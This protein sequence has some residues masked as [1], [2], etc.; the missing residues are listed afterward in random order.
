[1]GRAGSPAL[2]E[3]I[4]LAV[5]V[6][7]IALA[8]TLGE[9]VIFDLSALDDISSDALPVLWLTF[10]AAV[11]YLLG[12]ALG[13]ALHVGLDQA[14]HRLRAVPTAELVSGAA[15]AA[16]GFLVSLAL[17]WPVLLF[18]GWEV[19]IPL[20]VLVS[21]VLTA[22]GAKLGSSRGGELLRF[23]G[24]SGRLPEG[25]IRH[26]S[27]KIVDSSA[28]VDGRIVDVCRAGFLDG[29]LVIPGFVLTEVQSL[30]DA[31]DERRRSRG[32]RALDVLAALQRSA[33]VA[34][35]VSDEDYPEIMEVDAKLLALA[36]EANSS[37]VTVDSNLGR[38]AEVQGIRVLNLHALAETLRPPVLPG[39][40]LHLLITRRGKESGQGVGHLD[41]GTMVVVEG[42]ANLEGQ[43]V[44]AEVSS[45]L[46]TANGRLVFAKLADSVPPTDPV[47]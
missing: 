27:D 23:V 41:D 42:A 40:A 34:I 39:D 13:R 8:A 35:S 47:L 24:V 37:L 10:A 25:G 16:A 44:E 6:A 1:V 19:T 31:A 15:G 38:I 3:L 30:A 43:Q 33:G 2:V 9:Q 18:E 46:A 12:G 28:L 22:A 17:V 14:E 5:V 29:T 11:S 7:G 4:R 32:K 36:R 21:A 20:A 45:I 26:G